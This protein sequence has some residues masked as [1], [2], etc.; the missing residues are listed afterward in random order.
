MLG[1]WHSPKIWA[2][3][4]RL[5]KVIRHRDLTSYRAYFVTEDNP[6]KARALVARLIHTDEITYTLTAFPDVLQ[7]IVGLESGACCACERRW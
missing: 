1:L 4:P 2:T 6:L 5:S 3:N 7:Q